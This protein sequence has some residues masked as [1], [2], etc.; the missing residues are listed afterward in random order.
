VDAVGQCRVRQMFGPLP[1][2]DVPRLLCRPSQNSLDD[3][4]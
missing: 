4:L 1:Y 3:G 2:R